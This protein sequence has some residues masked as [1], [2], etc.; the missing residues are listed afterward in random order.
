MVKRCGF[1]RFKR[2]FR[3]FRVKWL[4]GNKWYQRYCRKWGHIR[5]KWHCRFGWNKWYRRFRRF[6][7]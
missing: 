7:R 6:F 5:Y 4:I 2:K 3:F 1:V